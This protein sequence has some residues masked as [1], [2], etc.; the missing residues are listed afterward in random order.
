MKKINKIFYSTKTGKLHNKCVFC[1]ENIL[2]FEHGYVIEKAFKYNDAKNIYETIFEYALCTE[3][4]QRLSSE[5]SE[6]SKNTIEAYFR[7]NRNDAMHRLNSVKGRLEECLITNENIRNSKEYQI[8]GFFIKNE[9]LVSN[10]FPYAI[11][12]KAINEI[13]DLISKKTRDFSEKFKDLILPPHVKDNLPKN[14]IVI[15]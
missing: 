8:A 3:C 7:I 14:R 15:F 2:E 13:Q 11:G 1:E 4:L 12:E 6:K 9:M 10:D 5:M